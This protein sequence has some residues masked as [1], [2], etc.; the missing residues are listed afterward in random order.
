MLDLRPGAPEH[1]H[2]GVALPGIIRLVLPG[3][4]DG[5]TCAAIGAGAAR[6]RIPAVIG[7]GA[8]ASRP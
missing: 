6:R 5:I 1:L 3:F 4:A 8:R 7:A 2:P